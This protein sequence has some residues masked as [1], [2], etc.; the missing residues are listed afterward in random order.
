MMHINSKKVNFDNL[1]KKIEQVINSSKNYIPVNTENT[2]DVQHQEVKK[3]IAPSA[4]LKKYNTRSYRLLKKIEALLFFIG[5]SYLANILKRTFKKLSYNSYDKNEKVYVMSDFLKYED[6]EFIKNVYLG[7]LNREVEPTALDS[8]LHL[9]YTGKRTKMDILLFIRYSKEGMQ[10]NV[11]ILGSKKRYIKVLLNKTP[12]VGYILQIIYTLIRIPK[13]ITRLN[14]FEAVLNTKVN[15]KDFHKD[16]QTKVSIEDFHKEIHKKVN[17][18]D[19]HKDIQTKVNIDEFNREIKMKV[20]LEYFHKELKSKVSAEN[21]HK[22]L[23]S[24]VS[25]EDFYKETQKKVNLEDFHKDIKTKVSLDDFN[26]AIKTKISSED[27]HKEIQKK[28]NLEDFHK[29]MYATQTQLLS[30]QESVD[31]LSTQVELFSKDVKEANNYLK[32]VEMN[33]QKLVE[34]A[35][36][37]IKTANTEDTTILSAIIEE[38][39]HILDALYLSFEDR[40]RGERS[41]IKERQK[42]YLPVVKSVIKNASQSL[43]DIGCGRGEWLELLKENSIRAKGIDLN[44]LMVKAA[45]NYDLDVTNED[46]ISYLRKL[47]DETLDV[48]TGFHIVEH[49]KF[50]VL[51]SLFDEALRVLKKGGKVIFETPNPENLIVGSCSFYTDPTHLNPIPPVTLEFLAINRGFSNVEIHR[52]HPIKE[53]VLSNTTDEDINNLIFASTKEQDYSI[54]GTK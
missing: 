30:N 29:D 45:R 25:A 8:L 20:N 33:L 38:K 22:E 24:K 53:V 43:L 51:I 37:S 28:V 34:K 39:E 32:Y 2:E 23:K 11:T 7:L 1:E 40:F 10:N 4:S 5:F 16:I 46:A 44:R 21:F 6:E 17:L 15:L 52:L 18:E 27:F 47:D 26:S 12:V 41:G 14:A 3:P 19:F 42:Y 31:A 36:S 35:E 50:E 13:L 54:I 49:L 9:L 48:I